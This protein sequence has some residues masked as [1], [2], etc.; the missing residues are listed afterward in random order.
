MVILG[1]PKK[2]EMGVD[3]EDLVKDMLAGLDDV[4]DQKHSSRKIKI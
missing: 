3:D 2:K 4:L 1:E